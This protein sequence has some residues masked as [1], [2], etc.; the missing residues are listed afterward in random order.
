MNEASSPAE[1]KTLN[2]ETIGKGRIHFVAVLLSTVTISLGVIA[3]LPF[4]YVE[5]SGSW[6]GA[7]QTEEMSRTVS[8]DHMPTMAGWPLQYR[9]Q[10]ASD[11]PLEPRFWSPL[12]LASNTLFFLVVMVG[13]YGY[14]CYRG[15]YITKSQNQRRAQLLDAGTAMAIILIPTLILGTEYYGAWKHQKTANQLGRSGNCFLAIW[16]PEVLVTRVPPGL[17]QVLRRIRSID[18]ISADANT[19]ALACQTP[20]V[21]TITCINCEVTAD[22][23]S[24]LVDNPHFRGLQISRQDLDASLTDAIADLNHLTQLDLSNTNFDSTQLSELDHLP[25][26]NINLT[27]TNLQLS[28]LGKPSWSTTAETLSLSR[29]PKGFT[30]ALEIQAWPQ[31][32]YLRVYRQT[33]ISNPSVLKVRLADLPALSMVSL[34]RNQQHDLELKNLPLLSSFDEGLGYLQTILASDAKI[35]GNMWLARFKATNTPS[36]KKFGCYARDLDELSLEAMKQLRSLDLGSYQVSVTN[37]IHTDDTPLENSDAWISQLGD[38]VGPSTLNLMGL[39]LQETDLS[40]LKNNSGIRH[41][42][43]IETGISFKQVKQLAGMKQL[44]S[45]FIRDCE[46]EQ[47]SLAWILNE[48]PNLDELVINGESLATVDVSEHEHLRKL[49]ITK[50]AKPERVSLVDVPLLKTE[51]HLDQCPQQLEI[52]NAKSMTGLSVNAPWPK[53]GKLQGMRDLDWFAVGGRN[54]TDKLID[55]VLVCKK[56]DQLTLAYTSVSTSRLKQIGQLKTLSTLSV[57]GSNIDPSV[58]A[59]WTELKSLWDVNLDDNEISTGT[60][61]WLGN[62]KSLRR[63]SLNRTQLKNQA[64]EKLGNLTQLSELQLA[65]VEIDQKQIRPLL[66]ANNIESLNLS[67]WQIDNEMMNWLL[68]T[69]SLMLLTLHDCQITPRQLEQFMDR[70]PPISLDLGPQSATLDTETQRE[71]ERRVRQLTLGTI[72]GWRTAIRKRF[73]QRQDDQVTYRESDRIKIENFR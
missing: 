66:Q 46:V 43:L 11:Q 4:K 41:L 67:G 68:D 72:E 3:N 47:E 73:R 6:R 33:R 16:I 32:R 25:L 36:L 55:E 15:N 34:D 70:M 60:L 24:P 28:Q 17:Q 2:H 65:G 13:V 49:R 59:A 29:P 51:L 48:F 23:L 54:V 50:L 7:A 64:P 58:I 71:L 62:I 39:P 31:L 5:V 40:P 21:V 61:V 18:L 57:P 63:L 10:Y 22:Q 53:H 42:N 56:L 35:P 52:S 20:G 38:R 27:N 30:D 9:I 19:T 1:Q 26:K 12:R 14:V 8:D 69:K 45:L 44:E 37:G